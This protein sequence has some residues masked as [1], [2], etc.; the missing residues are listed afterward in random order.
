VLET[1]DD[2]AKAVSYVE[3]MIEGN[4]PAGLIAIVGKNLR[5]VERVRTR[6]GQGRIALQGAI[7][8][9]WL[10]LIFS[11]ISSAVE[12]SSSTGLGTSPAI[13]IGAGL[14][15][16]VNVLRFTMRRNKR[17]FASQSM[18]IASEYQVQVPSNLIKE[19]RAAAA[20][21]EPSNEG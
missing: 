2:Y 8:G 15:M 6:V 19:A 16:I 1:F 14:G 18:I 17:N 13:I 5:S 9:S 3:R 21:L 20:S 4:F 10:G 11:M 12:G 7:T